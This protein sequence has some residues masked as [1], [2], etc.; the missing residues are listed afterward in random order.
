MRWVCNGFLFQD[1]NGEEQGNK[2]VAGSK[3]AQGS[4]SGI[5]KQWSS[6][7]Q[8][9]VDAE[10]LHEFKKDPGLFMEEKSLRGYQGHGSQSWLRKSPRHMARD[11]NSLLGSAGSLTFIHAVSE[12]PEAS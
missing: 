5:M 6:L 9:A 7:L 8:D 1:R 11:R 10:H 2:E 3:Q 12:V 4:G